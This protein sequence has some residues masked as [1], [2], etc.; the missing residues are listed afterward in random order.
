MRAHLRRG[1]T[2][3]R[4]DAT[5]LATAIATTWRNGLPTHIWEDEL[6]TNYRDAERARRAIDKLKRTATFAP[7]IA[8][9]HDAYIAQP[10]SVIEG[11]PITCGD[12][13]NSGWTQAP[14]YQRNGH[15][16]TAQQPCGH[17]KHGTRAQQSTIWREQQAR[18][19][20]PAQTT[21]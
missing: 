16:Y 1:A 2:L 9:F 7:A 19:N 5:E 8:A 11:D 14:D 15:T 3:N 4:Q 13:S 21:F 12:C 17:C 10:S 6:Q 20:Q 18:T